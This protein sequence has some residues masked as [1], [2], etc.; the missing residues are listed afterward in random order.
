[1][2][3][4]TEIYGAGEVK[5]ANLSG[6]VLADQIAEHHPRVYFEPD[7]LS[8]PQFLTRL[9]RTGDLLL[10][11]SA[12]NLNQVISPTMEQLRQCSIIL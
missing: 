8:L 3:V 11:L 9:L 1:V 12:G 10:F 5:I 2:V 4:I 6:Q 7:L